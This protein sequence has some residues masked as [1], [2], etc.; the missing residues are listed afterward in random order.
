MLPSETSNGSEGTAYRYTKKV[1]M[2]LPNRGR[3]QAI[4]EEI[5]QIK[6]ISSWTRAAYMDLRAHFF[7]DGQCKIRFAPG[8]ARI[9]F[10]AL[11][12][13]TGDEQLTEIC[14]LHDIL[15]IISIAHSTEYTRHL[16][17]I[18][19]EPMSFQ[20]LF[21]MYGSTVTKDWSSLKRKLKRRKYGER[22]YR[23]I[24]LD[25]FETANKY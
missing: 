6:G 12:L 25:C 9:A 13:G 18:G 5:A 11:E 16:A 22:K 20:D 4:Y 14:N 15:R 3:L 7:K 21:A 17:P 19:G 23:I 8:A 10:G 1:L 24:E 2:A